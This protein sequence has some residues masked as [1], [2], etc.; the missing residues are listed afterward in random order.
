MHKFFITFIIICTFFLQDVLAQ[1]VKRDVVCS[2]GGGGAVG[3]TGIQIRCT[4]AQPPNVGTVSTGPLKLRQG[5][6][7]PL[8]SACADAPISAFSIIEENTDDCNTRF[9]FN[10]EGVAESNTE[11]FWDFGVDGSPLLSVEENP[12]NISFSNTGEK[13][14]SLT[15]TTDDCSHTFSKSVLVEDLSTFSVSVVVME[16]IC[17]DDQDGYVSLNIEG[18]ATP[19]QIDWSSGQTGMS[20]ISGLAAGMYIYTVT[21]ANNCVHLDTVEV[22]GNDSISLQLN[23]FNETCFDT[24]DGTIDLSISGGTEPYLINWSEGSDVQSLTQ[25]ENGSY[26]VTVT[27]SEGCEKILSDIEVRTECQNLAMSDVFTPNGDGSNDVW[28]IPNVDAFPENRLEIY[29]RWGTLI[30]DMDGYDNNW[31]GT[32]NSGELLSAGAYYYILELNDSK[33]TAYQGSVTILR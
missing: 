14:I 31:K 15:V 17:F 19:V 21:D 23:I 4:A 32:N 11:F 7:Q 18:A 27:D 20:T 10:Y 2:A 12:Q 8:S 16:V 29:N 25:I 13:T 30:F 6:Q 22:L 26:A 5:F 1:G 33:N 24:K 28:V 9:H 3:N